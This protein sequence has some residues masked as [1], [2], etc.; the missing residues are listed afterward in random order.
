MGSNDI[1]IVCC[2]VHPNHLIVPNLVESSR[3]ALWLHFY[4]K[5]PHE[6]DCPTS[7]AFPHI[8]HPSLPRMFFCSVGIDLQKNKIQKSKK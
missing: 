3:S 6:M 2:K 4:H 1:L 5:P 8:P 7:R